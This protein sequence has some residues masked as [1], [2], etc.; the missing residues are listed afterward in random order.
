MHCF[1]ITTT[2]GITLTILTGGYVRQTCDVRIKTQTL[3][4]E[5]RFL[6]PCRKLLTERNCFHPQPCATKFLSLSVTRTATI[7]QPFYFARFTRNETLNSLPN[8][9]SASYKHFSYL[10]SSRVQISA[11]WVKHYNTV[12]LLS[13]YPLSFWAYPDSQFHERIKTPFTIWKCLHYFL[14]ITKHGCFKVFIWRAG[15]VLWI[16]FARG[17][18]MAKEA[19]GASKGRAR[20]IY[21]VLFS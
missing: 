7:N 1:L 9:Q 12:L 15:I 18:Q 6:H 5:E 20:E 2:P 11:R 13:F 16:N 4:G 14:S 3:R 21:R 19:Y 10:H 17:N 8:W